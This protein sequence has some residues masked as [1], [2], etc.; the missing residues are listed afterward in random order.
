M[1][2]EGLERA[3]DVLYLVMESR[4]AGDLKGLERVVLMR[5]A[6]SGEVDVVGGTEDENDGD[7]D[8]NEEDEEDEEVEG[9]DEGDEESEDDTGLDV[10]FSLTPFLQFLELHLLNYYFLLFL[11]SPS[12]CHPFVI[13]RYL[14]LPMSSLYSDYSVFHPL[15]PSQNIH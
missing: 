15:L 7:D 4:E 6:W 10:S 3:F 5:G 14:L 8:G 9:D 1:R 12:I 13:P 11:P 2:C